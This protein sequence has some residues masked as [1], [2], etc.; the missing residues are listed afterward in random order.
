MGWMERKLDEIASS[1][2][3][4]G[5]RTRLAFASGM[6]ETLKGLRIKGA[7]PR[8]IIPNAVNQASGG[9]L[10]GWSVR[11]SGGD[12]TL[13]FRD[14]ADVSGDP[15]GTAAITNGTSSTHPLM[16]AGISFVSSLFVEV[17]GAGTPVGAV[18]IGAVD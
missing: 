7:R 4:Q 12:V 5:E 16:P 18:W 14:G 9:R 17:T 15:I 11:A 1:V 2:S 3:L 6:A 8:P 10:V 13:T